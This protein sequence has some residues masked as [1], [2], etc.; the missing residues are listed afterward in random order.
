VILR[1]LATAHAASYLTVASCTSSSLPPRQHAPVSHST[2]VDSACGRRSLGSES[3]ERWRVQAVEVANDI[4][5]GN[6]GCA[7]S[8]DKIESD[9][10]ELRL[11]AT[12]SGVAVEAYA[13]NE[14]QCE[15]ARCLAR[16]LKKFGGRFPSIAEKRD[17]IGVLTSV[18]SSEGG[19]QLVRTDGSKEAQVVCEERGRRRGRLPKE[20]IQTVVRSQFDVFR[21]CYESGLARNPKLSGT[22]VTMFTIETDGSVADA[23]VDGS[24]PD[25]AVMRCVADAIRTLAFDAPDGNGIV[26]VGYPIRFDVGE[27]ERTPQR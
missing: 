3:K 22:V 20:Y 24:L 16:S 19:P 1:S 6:A 11:S 2:S 14:S 12:A 8:L 18:T 27:T 5:R 25:C 10:I 4:V 7:K 15:A 17:A 9:S 21:R 13:H 26:T 23:K